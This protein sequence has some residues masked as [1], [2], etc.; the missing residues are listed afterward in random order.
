MEPAKIVV[1]IGQIQDATNSRNFP[2]LVISDRSYERLGRRKYPIIGCWTDRTHFVSVIS[3]SGLKQFLEG[4]EVGPPINILGE[5]VTASSSAERIPVVIP[6][7]GG[8]G[9]SPD[10]VA[11]YDCSIY[12]WVQN[13]RVIEMVVSN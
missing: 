13:L 11:N 6:L 12:K 10:C 8:K 5:R 3:I 2:L 9:I 7:R 4:E 1:A